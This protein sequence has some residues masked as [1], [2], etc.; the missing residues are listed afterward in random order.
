M[1]NTQ[2]YHRLERMHHNAPCNLSY[3]PDLR[4][5]VSEGKAEITL[6][7]R[8][9]YFHA[10]KAVHGFVYFKLL[11]EAGFYAAN[12]LVE[13]VFVLTTDFHTNLLRPVTTGTLR[14]VGQVVHQSKSQILAEAVL[15]NAEGKQIARGSGTFVKGQT[16][17]N[18]DI[19]YTD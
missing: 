12:S 7:V 8:S 15:Y 6:P 19:G 13:D 16:L 17:L 3:Y 2:H 10:A 18:A 14:A 11:D 9:E 5:S 4:I 1:P